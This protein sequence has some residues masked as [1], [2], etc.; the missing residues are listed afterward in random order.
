MRVSSTGLIATV[1]LLISGCDA[2]LLADAPADRC[3]EVGVQCVL[4]TGP[5]GVCERSTCESGASGPCFACVS[6]H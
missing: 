2:E 6:Q 1:A 4:P 3:T 5:L